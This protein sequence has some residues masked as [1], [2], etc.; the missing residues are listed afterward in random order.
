MEHLNISI[1]KDF[2]ETPGARYMTDG[3]FSG[4]E[5]L[6]S[7]LRPKFIEGQKSG[8]KLLVDLDGV[9]GFA[10]SFLEEAFGGLSREFGPKA[11]HD[12]LQFKAEDE[13]GLIEEIWSYI[14]D[15]E[16]NRKK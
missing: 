16:T 11:L 3:D 15:C 7:I 13:P 8:E 2:T 12:V 14:D 9:S 5:F 6:N 10:T 1:S 4:E